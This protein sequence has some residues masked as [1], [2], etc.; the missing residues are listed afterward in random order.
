MQHVLEADKVQADE[1]QA[2]EDPMLHVSLEGD[3][4]FPL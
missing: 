1:D 3:Q 4:V 2:D